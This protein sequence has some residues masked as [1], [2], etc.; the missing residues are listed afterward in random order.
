MVRA[1]ELYT[2]S[3]ISDLMTRSDN[4]AILAEIHVISMWRQVLQ[5]YRFSARW[6]ATSNVER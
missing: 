2:P 4:E 5:H 3:L 1:P 6:N